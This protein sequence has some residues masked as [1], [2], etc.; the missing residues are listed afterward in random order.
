MP[1]HAAAAAQC[2][3]PLRLA[4]RCRFRAIIASSVSAI[5]RRTFERCPQSPGLDR[6]QAEAAD[7][8]RE[9]SRRQLAQV[10]DGVDA[11]ALGPLQRGFEAL[12]VHVS[13]EVQRAEERRQL[14]LADLLGM[15]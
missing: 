10:C 2:Q 14:G 3:P 5:A 8:I 15:R 12:V 11:S 4:C 7:Q 1:I 13:I 6:R 9:R